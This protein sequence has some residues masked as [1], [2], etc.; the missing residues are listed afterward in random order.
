[1][2]SA[3]RIAGTGHSLP[4]KIVTNAELERSG[5][6]GSRTIAAG[7]TKRHRCPEGEA[8]S[9]VGAAAARAAMAEAG[10]AIEDVDLIVTSSVTPD[11]GFPS[12]A[13]LIQEQLGAKVFFPAF[14]VVAGVAGFTAA[15]S[16]AASFVA[17]GASKVA[18]VVAAECP[19]RFERPSDAEYGGFLGDGA[20][21]VVLVPGEGPGL[22]ERIGLVGGTPGAVKGAGPGE[23][24]G[25][26]LL[27]PGGY[28]AHPASYETI[29]AGLHLFRFGAEF[30]ERFARACAACGR[31]ALS[32]EGA[33]LLVPPQAGE[34]FF[35]RLAAFLGVPETLLLR[36]CADTGFTLSASQP[37]ALDRALRAGRVKAGSSVLLFG[38]DGPHTGG[39]ALLRW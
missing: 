31:T 18:L 32:D 16:A 15:L 36:D 19:S 8:S 26:L 1:M 27:L 35:G 3:V 33:T 12:T 7:F 21:A 24:A 5:G 13:C 11:L 28:S 4:L 39:Y 9:H 2:P 10:V 30:E 23:A 22:V 38:A 37:L 17:A 29:D 6:L 34:V 20:G 25:P 14:D